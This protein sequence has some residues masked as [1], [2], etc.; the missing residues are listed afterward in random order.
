MH[1]RATPA[2]E[3]IQT[4]LDGAQLAGRCGIGVAR[5]RRGARFE[6]PPRTC[7]CCRHPPS[8]TRLLPAAPAAP[9]AGSNRTTFA[10]TVDL[11]I[12]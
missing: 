12:Y 2:L 7:P 10:T 11:L 5:M 1:H 8:V 4:P 9:A 3:R 6:S